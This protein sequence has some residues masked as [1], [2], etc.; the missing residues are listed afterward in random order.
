M[1]DESP[2]SIMAGQDYANYRI[3]LCSNKTGGWIPIQ[4][5][6][7]AFPG[8]IKVIKAHVPA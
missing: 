3:A 4:I 8:V 2:S 1:M 5:F 7:D 6:I